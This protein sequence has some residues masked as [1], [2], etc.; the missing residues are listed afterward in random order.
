MVPQYNFRFVGKEKID[1]LELYVFDVSPKVM[2][3]A[4]KTK[5]RFFN[6]RIWVDDRDLM[7]VKSKGKALPET[8][9]A[10]Y[11]I[12]ETWRE[13]VDGKYWFPS[14]SYADDELVFDNG[15]TARI[16]MKVTYKDYALGRT[17]VKVIDEEEVYVEPTPTPSPTP[18]KP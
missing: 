17:D 2:P 3:D 4:K 14:Y 7:I 6:G 8:K 12:V 15:Y 5:E 1:V 13:N 10:K 16:R 9:A 18:K 11:P